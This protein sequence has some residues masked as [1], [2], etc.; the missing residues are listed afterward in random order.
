MFL[1]FAQDF[2]LLSS[3]LKTHLSLTVN[4]ELLL[5]YIMSCIVCQEQ[6]EEM[7]D[8]FV[9][10]CSKRCRGVAKRHRK[11]RMNGDREVDKIVKKGSYVV[12]RM[13]GA[14][15][16]VQKEENFKFTFSAAQL[17]GERVGE[18]QSCYHCFLTVESAI[19][20][21]Y[22]CF[23]D[24]EEIYVTSTKAISFSQESTLAFDEPKLVSSAISVAGGQGRGKYGNFSA[25]EVLLFQTLLHE[26]SSKPVVFKNS[27]EKKIHTAMSFFDAFLKMRNLSYNEIDEVL[28]AE[29]IRNM[30]IFA[31]HK[32]LCGYSIEG[33]IQTYLPNLALGL[34]RKNHALHEDYRKIAYGVVER[35][36]QEGNLISDQFGGE[37][38]NPLMYFDA[39]YMFQNIPNGWDQAYSFKA[40]VSVGLCCGARGVSLC[41]IEWNNITNVQQLEAP[42]SNEIMV[43]VTLKIILS[44]GGDVNHSITFQGFLSDSSATNPVFH[45]DMLCL[46]KF[47][48]SLAQLSKISLK[49]KN[50][51]IFECKEPDQFSQRLSKVSYYCGYEEGFFTAHSLRSG[52]I[53]S[54]TI[55][56]YLKG[57]A[58]NFDILFLT[59]IVALWIPNST[60]Q[61]CYLKD[62][63]RRVL[64]SNIMIGETENQF[65]GLSK[66]D[67][68]F[69]KDVFG[70]S[71]IAK[72]LLQP[73]HFHGIQHD[74]T[75]KWPD[76]CTYSGLKTI[77]SNAIQ[78]QACSSLVPHHYHCNLIMASL[79]KY[80][81]NEE[82]NLWNMMKEEQ[83]NLS[84]RR[85]ACYTLAKCSKDDNFPFEAF[86][87]TLYHFD[88]DK[89]VIQV[90]NAYKQNLKISQ[91]KTKQKNIAITKVLRDQQSDE[92]G[93]DEKDF[94]DED[95]NIETLHDE[96]KMKLRESNSEGTRSRVKWSS[97][98]D[99]ILAQHYIDELAKSRSNVFVRVALYLGERTSQDCSN[100]F[101][102]IKRT[103]S[104]LNMDIEQVAQWMIDKMGH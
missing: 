62:A 43:Q 70:D 95:L 30:C 44:K 12:P 101:K 8:Q 86:F 57:S 32:D 24:K 74:M 61:I 83:P 52:Y 88:L 5:I 80:M 81:K 97:I 93:A 11:K 34:K 87:S 79:S 56:K 58:N 75:L 103:Y 65:K 55:Q 9:L 2:A 102:A 84:D 31:F 104:F 78:L 27:V 33:F 53:C 59:G 29:L 91:K 77:I 18:Q 15:I 47:G 21:V 4:K 26:F 94:E 6:F 76:Q 67:S 19:R 68:N 66:E 96:A 36:K 49:E 46:L 38:A 10:Y 73:K 82:F 64:V 85:L 28:D 69:L 14:K 3:P 7:G 13:K 92:Y 51:L 63:L 41:Q 50:C 16:D 100:R 89:E 20:L 99:F 45:L 90:A 54:A 1:T 39:N 37:G 35:L 17:K 98:E 60:S 22:K 48:V 23:M 72:N 42:N 71:I 25:K 40:H